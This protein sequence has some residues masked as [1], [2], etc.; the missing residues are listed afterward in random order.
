MTVHLNFDKRSIELFLVFGANQF[1]IC[2][3]SARNV[4]KH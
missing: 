4:L 2:K 1:E 3:L